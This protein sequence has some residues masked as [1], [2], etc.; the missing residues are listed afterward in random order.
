[1]QALVCQPAVA[2]QLF[3]AEGVVGVIFLLTVALV[4]TGAMI[5]VNSQR[6]APVSAA[7]VKLVVLAAALP[8]IPVVLTLVPFFDLVRWLF[9]KVV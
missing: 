7:T 2:P 8:L 5:A 1:M 3:S 6:L 9:G 4:L